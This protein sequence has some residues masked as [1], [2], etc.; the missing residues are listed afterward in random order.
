MSSNGVGSLCFLNTTVNSSVYQDILDG[1]MIPSSER[2]FPD[3]EFIYQHDL[4]PAHASKSTAK[5][6]ADRH[7]QVLE[8]PA[9]SPDANPIEFLWAIAKR[10][11]QKLRPSKKEELKAA[12]Q[13][14]WTS[15]TQEDCARLVQSMP[16]RIAAIIRSKGAPT[17][18]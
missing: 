12:I 4:A 8:W 16:R 3:G 1:H 13:Q 17:R 5:W 10:R 15:I 2:L 7:V 11:L 9:N 18:Y 14:I 6:L